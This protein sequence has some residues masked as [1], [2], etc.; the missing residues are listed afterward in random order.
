MKKLSLK[1]RLVNKLFK[2]LDIRVWGVEIEA[3]IPPEFLITDHASKRMLERFGC[4]E[5]KIKKI[6]VKAWFSKEKVNKLWEYKKK[7]KYKTTI[8]K[9]FCGHVFVFTT[10]RRKDGRAQKRLIT[11]YNPKK[12]KI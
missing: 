12:E 7:L 5:N 6:T 3:A 11:V 8:Y 2:I 10:K 1:T 4:S 9:Y